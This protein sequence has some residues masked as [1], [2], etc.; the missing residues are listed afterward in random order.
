MT[1]SS[2]D[3]PEVPKCHVLSSNTREALQFLVEQ[4][5]DCCAHHKKCSNNVESLLS[6]QYPLRLLDVGPEGGPITLRSTRIFTNQEYICLSH[7]WGK[8]KPYTL[9]STTQRDLEQGINCEDLPQT[10][11]DA[12]YVTR[13]LRV[14]YLWIDSL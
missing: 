4:Y 12:I 8:S 9:N 14:Q 1:Y 13:C 6:G 5:H 10:F 7:C 3:L 11:Q 2:I